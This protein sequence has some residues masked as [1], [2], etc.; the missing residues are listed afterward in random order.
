VSSWAK[1]AIGWAKAAGLFKS[2]TDIF[3]KPQENATRSL[4][5]LG[6]YDYFYLSK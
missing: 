3:T 5:A 2:E 4:L 6:L 1:E